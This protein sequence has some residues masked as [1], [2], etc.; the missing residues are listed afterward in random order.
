MKNG[1]R[2]GNAPSRPTRC[3]VYTRKSTTAGL[4]QEFNSLDAQRDA[5]TS[6][7]QRQSGW[8]LVNERYDDG[9]YSGS[10]VERP[11]FQR[12][13]SDIDARKIDVILVYKVDRLSRSLLDFARVMERFAALDVA[14]VSVTQNFSTA[15]A[16]GR[17]TLHMLMSF[18]QFEREMV[19]ERTR[20]KIAAARRKGKWT[21]GPVPLGYTVEKGRLKVH[22]L[23]AVLVRKI[24]ALYEQHRSALSV[25]RLL[26]ERR[27][28][29]RCRTVNGKVRASRPWSTN[30]IL[31]VLKNPVYAGYMPYDNALHA[32]EHTPIITVDVFTQ[33]QAQLKSATRVTGDRKRNLDYVLRGLLRCA[34]CGGGFTAASSRS[35]RYY[36]CTTRY[37][38]G[39]AACPSQPLPAQAIESY[40]YEHLREA[41]ADGALATEV[42]ASVQAQAAV[43][44]RD[45]ASE[46]QRLPVEIAAL[47]DERKRLS[48][49]SEALT[50]AAR[51]LVDERL[52][53]I[54]D[55][56]ARYEGRLYD[57]E[58][59]LAALDTQEVEL[60][61]VARCLIDFDKMWDVLTPENR[62]RLMRTVI[63]AVEVNEPQ[64]QVRVTMVDLGAELVEAR[65]PT[66]SKGA[67]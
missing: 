67:R 52:A 5:C 41:L 34:C 23:E 64:N 46:Q 59:D 30:D 16:L 13:L 17:L 36:R 48:E 32:G 3:A 21:G 63:R 38:Q 54:G 65:M 11:A 14:F 39:S 33:T 1:K 22:E 12:L 20:D 25:A 57:A 37:R 42:A 40:V 61:W 55:Q 47:S 10:N 7:L 8:T 15:D 44:R 26:N 19:S 53:Q 60:G 6:Y 45:I 27:A 35:H 62:A 31:R 51:R 18:A 58:R 50:G 2:D 9:G 56:I 24:F 49:T 28:P 29:K 4:E 66:A 43:R